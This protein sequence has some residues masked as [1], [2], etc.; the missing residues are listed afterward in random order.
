MPITQPSKIIMAVPEYRLDQIIGIKSGSLSI[1]APTAITEFT[2]ASATFTTGFGD[3][4]LF[5]GVFSTDSGTSWND[6]GAYRP[7][8]T[9][10]GQPV[11]QTVTCQGWVTPTGVF[12]AY[13]TNWY[14]FVHSTG[15]TYTIQYKIVFFAKD[16]QGLTTTIPTNEILTYDSSFNYLKIFSSG[17]F[18]NNTGSPSVVTHN[19]GYVPRVRAWI[20][21]SSSSPYTANSLLSYDWPGNSNFNIEVDSSSATFDAIVGYGTVNVLYRIYLD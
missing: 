15:T 5:Q 18:A 4:C 20:T 19:L 21:T 10:A 3:T 13:G 9:T 12:T 16:M 17:T 1:T 7:N 2:N 11:L 8:L 14:D 6:F